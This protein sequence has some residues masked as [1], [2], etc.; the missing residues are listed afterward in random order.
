[1]I[2]ARDDTGL[3]FGCTFLSLAWGMVV[4]VGH[5]ALPTI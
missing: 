3:G 1:M 2:R 4:F 5:C